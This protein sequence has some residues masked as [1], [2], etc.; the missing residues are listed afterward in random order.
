MSQREKHPEHLTRQTSL[1]ESL[2][3]IFERVPGVVE[4]SIQLFITE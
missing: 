3:Q 2:G 4:N 1:L